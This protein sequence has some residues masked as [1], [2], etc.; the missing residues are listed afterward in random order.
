[1]LEHRAGRQ[2]EPV[3]V[4]RHRP[5]RRVMVTSLM[6]RWLLTAVFTVA[7]LESLLALRR[8]GM[9][10]ASDRISEAFHVLMSA[11][12]I[13]MTWRSEPASAVWLQTALFGCAAVWFLLAGPGQMVPL[14]VRRLSGVHHALTA[15][16]MIWMITAMPADMRMTHEGLARAAMPAMSQPAMSHSS[17]HSSMPAAVK[18]V[19]VLLAAY[20]A[21]AAVL[22]SVW[23]CGPGRR[24]NG[25]PAAG[26]AAMSAGMAAMLLAML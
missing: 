14:A 8:V 18:A 5:R 20:F 1:M 11:A 24:V 19:S 23:A 21:L 3:P 7:G 6:A 26:D 12:L 25:R 9:T 15:G 16:A 13:A 2:G 4:S 22:W 10:R 17:S